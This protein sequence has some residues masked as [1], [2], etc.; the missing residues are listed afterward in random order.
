MAGPS[1]SVP[2]VRCRLNG[3]PQSATTLRYVPLGEFELWRFLMEKRHHR[4]VT[5]EAISVW[6]PEEA[7]R[8]SV[9]SVDELEPVVRV[10]FER[11]GPAGLGVP[12]ERFFPV[13][14]YPEAQAT[15]L[16]HFP[17]PGAA[18][19]VAVSPGYF[20]PEAQRLLSDLAAT[21]S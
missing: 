15:L 4:R 8:G 12:V 11:P 1:P 13:E 21:G 19:R 10:C 2:L 5:V 6:I 20:I 14:T 18:W 7:A 9:E 3:T 17:L 16:A